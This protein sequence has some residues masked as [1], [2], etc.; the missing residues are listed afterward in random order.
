MTHTHRI[1]IKTNLLVGC[2][3]EFMAL[4]FAFEINLILKDCTDRNFVAISS[5]QVLH[6]DLEVKH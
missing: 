6:F 4:Q 5:Q 2:L 1:V 3:E